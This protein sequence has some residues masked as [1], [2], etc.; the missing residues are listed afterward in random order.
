MVKTNISQFSKCANCG[1]CV[2]ACPANAIWVDREEMYYTPRVDD[3]KCVQCGKCVSVCPVNTP[4]KTQNLIGAYYGY[5]D[6]SAI[7]AGSSSGGMVHVLAQ[8]ILDEGGVVFGAAYSE[9]S[10][11]VVFRST[12]EVSLRALQKSKYVE[13]NVGDSFHRVKEE[14]E[15]GRSVLFCG[16]PCQSF[17]LKRYLGKEYEKLLVCDFSCGGLP[18]HQMYHEYLCNLEERFSAQVSLVDFRPKNFGWKSH[19]IYVR[20]ENGREYT[21][22]APLDPYYKGFLNS[23][24]KRDYCY[25]CDFADN[26]AADIILADFWLYKKLSDMDNQDRGISLVL[27]NT[28]K[29]E[30]VVREMAPGLVMQTLPLEKGS[31]NIKSGHMSQDK[32][33]RHMRFV[34]AVQADGFVHA[35]NREIPFSLRRTWKQ[36]LKQLIRKGK[37]E[38]SKET[39]S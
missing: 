26:H 36:L 15:K 23:L 13:S 38:G 19:S 14:L 29:G 11:S 1:A 27:T 20:F 21:R 12:D 8:K 24:S 9:D 16:T 17:G 2:N 10:H 7:L 31:Y 5:A 37:Y 35:I 32:I 6:D 34:K 22:L 33:E 39:R 3:T 4:T 30:R 28:E 18:S 25:R